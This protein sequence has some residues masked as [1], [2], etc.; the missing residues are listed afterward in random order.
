MQLRVAFI[1]IPNKSVQHVLQQLEVPPST[2]H[3]ILWKCLRF[4]SC[5][6]WLFHCVT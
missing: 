2:I 5:R 6:H 3:K 4:K 1:H